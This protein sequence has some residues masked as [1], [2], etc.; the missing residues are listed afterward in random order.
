MTLLW[1]VTNNCVIWLK[2]KEISDLYRAK[3][4]AVTW[5]M[6]FSI[7]IKISETEET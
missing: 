7:E 4:N 2:Q 6:Q 5:I 1:K 3:I